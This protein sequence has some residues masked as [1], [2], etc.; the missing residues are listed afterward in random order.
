MKAFVSEKKKKRISKTLL[1]AFKF[2]G[3]AILNNCDVS[4]LPYCSETKSVC[5]GTIGQPWYVTIKLIANRWAWGRCLW[6]QVVVPS[7][8]RVMSRACRYPCQ[9][10][11]RQPPP[12]TVTLTK[13][14]EILTNLTTHQGHPS[15][16]EGRGKL[17]H[18]AQFGTWKNC[19]TSHSEYVSSDAGRKPRMSNIHASS[20]ITADQHWLDFNLA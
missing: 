15:G 11:E 16:S 6:K 18:K 5:S 14:V 4:W 19:T 2:Q 12:G 9:L 8:I 7:K 1:V 3:V 13:S 10:R 17:P 20:A